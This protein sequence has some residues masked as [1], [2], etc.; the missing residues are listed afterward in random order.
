MD[1]V[2]ASSKKLYELANC[3]RTERGPKYLHVFLVGKSVDYDHFANISSNI[4]KNILNNEIRNPT[5]DI[6]VL[7]GSGLILN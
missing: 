6:L 3:Y 4:N 7:L 5:A 2:T 1:F